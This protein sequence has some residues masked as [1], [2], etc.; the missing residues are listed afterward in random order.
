MTTDKPA[1]EQVRALTD[2][3]HRA[4]T[5]RDRQ[6]AAIRRVTPEYLLHN[7]K[8]ALIAQ[9]EAAFATENERLQG[10][11]LEA[12]RRQAKELEANVQRRVEAKRQTGGYEEL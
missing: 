8:Q 10:E 9:A 6:I 1:Y 2:K 3:I 11:L 4:R 7:E 12:Q 5:D